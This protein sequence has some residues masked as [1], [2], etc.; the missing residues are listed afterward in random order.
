MLTMVVIGIW[1]GAGWTFV[2]WG[3]FNGVLLLINQAWQSVWGTGP[4]TKAGRL[5]GWMLTFTAFSVGGVF[6]RAV[7]IGTAWH[8]LKAMSGL[9]GPA[10]AMHLTLESDE[11]MIRS[12]YFSEAFVLSWF[13]TTWT[14]VATFWTA[15]ALAVAWLVPDTMEIT[16]YREGDAQTRWRRSLGAFAWQPSLPALG[17]VSVV[18]MAVFVMIGRVSEFLYYQF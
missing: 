10:T 13:G 1:H 5:V 18:F 12:G 2:A 7:D 14:M 16:D 8:L 11:W 9:A 15:L 17:V 3:A 6:F 4:G